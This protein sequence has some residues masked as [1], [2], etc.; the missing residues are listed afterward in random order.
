MTSDPTT[1]PATFRWRIENATFA[2][3]ICF[4]Q[5]WFVDF[6]ALHA[7]GATISMATC[8]S[9]R[10]AFWVPQMASSLLHTAALKLCMPWPHDHH[11][12]WLWAL[13]S[14]STNPPVYHGLFRKV[15][16][17]TNELHIMRW[18]ALIVLRQ[19]HSSILHGLIY[20]R[21]LANAWK[22]DSQSVHSC[23]DCTSH[24]K[25][26]QTANMLRLSDSLSDWT[27]CS[28]TKPQRYSLS[29][30]HGF[31]SC[32]NHIIGT[33]V[34][35][36]LS[37]SI[38][39]YCTKRFGHCKLLPGTVTNLKISYMFIHIWYVNDMWFFRHPLTK[40]PCVIPSTCRLKSCIDIDIL[41]P[42]WATYGL[43]SI[44]EH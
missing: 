27:A 8:S 3:P 33:I 26:K 41:M 36:I 32:A 11:L 2:S 23:N 4:F 30:L 9:E 1:L 5:A 43:V 34:S 38:C 31:S 16:L 39:I 14:T 13:Q 42:T 19:M 24:G 6:N 35:G 40:R 12:V 20:L 17:C 29:Q 21:H 25:T 22:Y 10:C 18:V 37:V 28:S 15:F 44:S 7:A